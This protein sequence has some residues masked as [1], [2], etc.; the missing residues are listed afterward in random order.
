MCHEYIKYCCLCCE[1]VEHSFFIACFRER[2]E[3]NEASSSNIIHVNREPQTNF[4]LTGC[5][6]CCCGS[7]TQLSDTFSAHHVDDDR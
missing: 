2:L 3:A 6:C 5:C 4:R 7:N 1:G